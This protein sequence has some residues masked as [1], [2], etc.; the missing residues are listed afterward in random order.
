MGADSGE[1]LIVGFTL[2]GSLD[3]YVLLVLCCLGFLV[4][5]FQKLPMSQVE[6]CYKYF[7]DVVGSSSL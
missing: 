3:F 4:R 2:K 7:M 1:D 5:E 6:F